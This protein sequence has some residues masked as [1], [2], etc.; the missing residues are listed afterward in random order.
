MIINAKPCTATTSVQN[1]KPV[2]RWLCSLSYILLKV[3]L[4]F[5]CVTIYQPVSQN[6]GVTDHHCH[7]DITSGDFSRLIHLH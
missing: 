1:I 3:L 4:A 6:N 5:H 7:T 2:F